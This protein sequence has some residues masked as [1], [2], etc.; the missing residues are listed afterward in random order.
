M[1]LNNI[2]FFIRKVGESGWC[3]AFCGMQ[4]VH[5]TLTYFSREFRASNGERFA[6]LLQADDRRLCTGPI[7]LFKREPRSI[8]GQPILP[9]IVMES[10]HNPAKRFHALSCV[11]RPSWQLVNEFCSAHPRWGDIGIALG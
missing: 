9:G 4:N 5:M 6:I 3:A 7:F 10:I 8:T 1:I 2:D 11:Q